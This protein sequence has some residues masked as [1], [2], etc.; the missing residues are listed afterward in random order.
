MQGHRYEL[1]TQM[2]R[3]NQRENRRNARTTR[4]IGVMRREKKEEDHTHKWA[5]TLHTASDAYLDE[6]RSTSTTRV[7]EGS[8]LERSAGEVSQTKREGEH[9]RRGNTPTVHFQDELPERCA[10]WCL[11]RLL[12]RSQQREGRVREMVPHRDRVPDRQPELR[13]VFACGMDTRTRTRIQTKFEK[14]ERE[15]HH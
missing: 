14:R 8:E 15:G 6:S 1:H 13:C 3:A 11:L 4:R 2:S 5:R 12:F 10:S 7:T 9:T